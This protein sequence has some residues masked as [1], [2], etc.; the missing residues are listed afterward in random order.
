MNKKIIAIAIAAAMTAPVAMADVKVSGRFGGELVD[1]NTT[2]S[3][4]F[5]DSG[6]GRLYFDADIGKAFVKVGYKMGF[7]G[8]LGTSLREQI[9]GYKFDGVTV[10][11]GRLNGAMYTL[12]GDKYKG[13]FL[14]MTEGRS[15]YQDSQ[16]SKFIGVVAKVGGGK[17][18]A[19]FNPTDQDGSNQGGAFG[20]SWKGKVG[21]VGVFAGYNNGDTPEADGDK[22][23]ATKLGASMKFGMAT[24]TA[25]LAKKDTGVSA[26]EEDGTYL[27]ADF[28]LGNGL[29]AGIGYGMTDD[30][31]ADDDTQM[32]LAVSKS[33]SK[34]LKIY[35]GTSSV[36]TNGGDAV[37]EVG[38]GIEARF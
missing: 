21:P 38:V 3:R 17:L 29:N 22:K 15:G 33:V 31:G 28:N 6:I 12:E 11:G 36:E 37:R 34:G 9:L 18:V 35:G 16:I 14:Q 7:A 30:G 27:T 32:R 19:N 4:D 20:I 10:Q 1:N 25:M 5:Q 13:T 2:E 23:A 24:I 8:T 26:T